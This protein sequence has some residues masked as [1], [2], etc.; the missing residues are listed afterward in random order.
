MQEHMPEAA[1]YPAK[2]VAP[3]YNVAIFHRPLR[4]QVW[5]H[6]VEHLHA[7]HACLQT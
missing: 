3:A 4:L 6:A 5:V 1:A 7:E 2:G